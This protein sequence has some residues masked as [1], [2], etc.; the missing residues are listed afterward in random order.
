MSHFQNI[1]ALVD[2]AKTG[3]TV[4]LTELIEESDAEVLADD[5]CYVITTLMAVLSH[6]ERNRLLTKFESEIT[7]HEINQIELNLDE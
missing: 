3:D 4:A 6:H 1:R 5:I 7:D 2:L